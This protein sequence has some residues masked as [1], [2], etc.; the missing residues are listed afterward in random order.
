[1]VVVRDIAATAA[2]LRANE[3]SGTCVG[4]AG[5]S[6][7]GRRYQQLRFATK[8]EQSP[9][10][11]FSSLMS[12][13]T[14]TSTSSCGDVDDGSSNHQQEKSGAVRTDVFAICGL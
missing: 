10:V 14:V 13:P 4:Y 5:T 9:G 7:Y 8:Y 12:G 3:C 11:K 6:S 2:S 1:M